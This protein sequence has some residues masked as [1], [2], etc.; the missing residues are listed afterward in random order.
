M[1]T[2]KLTKREVDRVVPSDH[3]VFVF[4]T[5]LKGF[6]LKVM[7]SGVKT[8]IVEYR[9]G[10]GGR[11]ATKRRLT[12]GRYGALTPEQARDLAKDILARVH[13]GE[14]PA[15]DKIK[16]RA[17]MTL[18]EVCALYLAEGC[19]TKKQSTI[20]TDSGRIRRHINPLL[21]RKRI[22]ELSRADV[23]KFMRDVAAGKTATDERTKKRGRAIVEGGKGTATRTVGLLGGIMSFA[24]ARGLRAGNPVRGVKRYPDK[25]GET[26]L[27]AAE[28][29]R[30]GQALVEAELAGANTSAVAIIRLLALTGA[31]KNEIASLRW[32]EVD[33]ERRYLKLGDSKT[34]AK[35]IPVGAPACEVLKTVQI[36]EGSEYVFPAVSGTGHF[37][38]V[39]KVWRT[40]RDAAN[41]PKLR[42][43]DL[44]HSFASIG[45]ARGD[46][47]PLIGAILGHADVK[48][49][50][51]YAHLADDPVRTA[52]EGISQSMQAAMMG[53]PAGK[54]VKLGAGRSRR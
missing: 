20:A 14:D 48:T 42:M 54:V 2:A 31:R 6:G 18:A 47:L 45:L 37:Q 17:E 12:I 5:D 3:I 1:T 49:T 28:L 38:G 40:V 30:I 44:R 32:N 11:K 43:H 23:E 29:A 50:A 27:S 33:L 9:A 52:A 51:R 10:A 46:T 22:G 15:S 53:M 4:D 8:F 26:F 16:A 36:V 41:F 35:V 24:V 7:P 34:G 25:K 39:D 13:A 19:E 21:G